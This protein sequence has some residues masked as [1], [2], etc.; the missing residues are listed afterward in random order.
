M[1]GRVHLQFLQPPNLKSSIND[2]K[3]RKEIGSYS[4]DGF[5]EDRENTIYWF[6]NTI[7][8]L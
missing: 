1:L 8:N 3:E 6:Q 2:T 7:Q 4:E 5:L